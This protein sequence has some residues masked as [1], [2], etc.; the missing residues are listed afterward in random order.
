MVALVHFFQEFLQRNLIV[1]IVIIAVLLVRAGLYRCPKKFSYFL[2]FFVG[3][4]M[5]FDISIPSGFSM[6]T[7]LRKLWNK[8]N[9][10]F[11]GKDTEKALNN[12]VE[13]TRMSTNTANAFNRPSK[14]AFYQG[15]QGKSVITPESE[16]AF[17]NVT[18]II[19]FALAIIWITVSIAILCYGIFTYMRCKRVV[20]QA[21]KVKENV[22]EC[23]RIYSPFVL[24][25]I[26]PQIY[27]PFHLEEQERIY[28]LAH[29]KYHIHRRDYV[30]KLLAFCF[31]AVYWMN[32]IV[33]LAFLL[34]S[35]DMEMSCDEAVLEKYGNQ[36]K[37]T[38]SMSLLHF[39]EGR[40]RFSFAPIA[41]GEDDVSKRIKNILNFRK[42]QVWVTGLL[43]L[44][45]GVIGVICLTNDQPKEP[46]ETLTIKEEQT[47]EKN[48]TASTPDKSGS[49]LDT[50]A[51]QVNISPEL[52]AVYM[53]AVQRLNDEKVFPNGQEADYDESG[54]KDNGYKI[55]DVD[56]DG[57]AELLLS[58]PG[59]MTMSGMRFLIY[60]FDFE[61]NEFYEELDEFP[62]ITI[63]DN[64]IIIAEA[65][66]NHGRS[67]LDDFWPYNVYQ[68]DKTRDAYERIANV[69]AWQYVMFEGATPDEEFP[70][71]QDL[72]GDGIVYYTMDQGYYNPMNIMD[73]AE[74]AEWREKLTED[75]TILQINFE[76]FTVSNTESHEVE[77]GTEK[78]VF[79][80]FDN[81]GIEEYAVTSL[82][83]EDPDYNGRLQFFWNGECV[84]DY[85]AIVRILHIA[86]AGY[87]DLDE[88]G[89]KEVYL[90]FLSAVNSMP[91]EE[92]IVLKQKGDN[93]EPLEMYQGEDMLHNGFPITI[94][95]GKGKSIHISC[96]GTEQVISYDLEPYWSGIQQMAEDEL[97]DAACRRIKYLVKE[98]MRQLAEGE[99][100]GSVLPWGIWEIKR[101]EYE[102]KNCLVASHG[103]GCI[104]RFAIG[105][106]NI[107][108]NYDADGKINILHLTFDAV[109]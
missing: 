58:Y 54:A 45:V 29:E 65:S 101:S 105:L 63:Y 56:G 36:I 6:F 95:G 46:E 79:A 100:Y 70:K 41:L 1:T 34:M 89:E 91:L 55:M 27:I 35:R 92:Y 68:Y 103:I 11:S 82:N 85:N 50:D 62:A 67:S 97:E 31:L 60:D 87:I 26:S 25:I 73:N 7:M 81:N 75:A 74:Y 39:A 21:V 20:K 52:Y 44:I 10:L 83:T 86:D 99:P 38:Y 4:R 64:G 102:G 23:D 14:D 109:Y 98:D 61:K 37:K 107:Y 9:I 53:D 32:P 94:I 51:A 84:Y 72:D 96:E 47:T 24:G 76:A 42:P 90:I 12:A 48:D 16:I 30:V 93:W 77:E 2:W 71:E 66:H 40:K 17:G 19:L 28:I 78:I 8:T 108:F 15:V 3:I 33:W 43:I 59:A 49:V 18:E 69:D 80:D 88:D 106:L 22:W 104:E 13:T 5:I 57:R